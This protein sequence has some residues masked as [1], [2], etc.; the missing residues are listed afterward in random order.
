MEDLEATPVEKE[1]PTPA[2]RLQN[3]IDNLP[4]TKNEFENYRSKYFSFKSIRDMNEEQRHAWNKS[5]IGK[6][7]TKMWTYKD[8]I[9]A[10]ELLTFRES[11][12]EFTI[13]DEI[14]DRYKTPQE[15]EEKQTPYNYL[16][17]E[18]N[19]DVDV[20]ESFFNNAVME[21]PKLNIE[22]E[23]NKIIGNNGK[24]AQ[25]IKK[26]QDFKEIPF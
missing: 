17:K 1:A 25:L 10:I 19:V 16:A 22:A 2:E 4:S 12:M 20:I 11:N 9:K 15:K 18:A 26:I 21:N 7:S 3:A 24:E 8:W 23:I 5:Q 13:P 6:E 14:P